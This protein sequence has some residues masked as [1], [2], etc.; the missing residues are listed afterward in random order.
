MQRRPDD[1]AAVLKQPDLEHASLADICAAEKSVMGVDACSSGSLL[2]AFWNLPK[3]LSVSIRVLMDPGYKGES[4]ELV[5]LIAATEYTIRVMAKGGDPL[6]QARE[7]LAAATG[8][9]DD[10]LN[11]VLES[12][13]ENLEKIESAAEGLV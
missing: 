12:F 8:L 11:T 2:A 10:R 7:K 4:K 13:Q 1:M 9:N 3:Y 5:H 6:Q